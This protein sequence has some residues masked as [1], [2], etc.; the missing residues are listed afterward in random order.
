VGVLGAEDGGEN[1]AVV[2]SW[3]VDSMG[4]L[5]AVDIPATVHWR[6][7]PVVIGLNLLPRTAR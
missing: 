3:G 1:N 2:A 6:P 4:L 5:L 7:S